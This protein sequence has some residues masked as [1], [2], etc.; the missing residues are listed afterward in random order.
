M[1]DET[2]PRPLGA[3]LVCPLLLLGCAQQNIAGQESRVRVMPLTLC[4]LGRYA[5]YS[6]IFDVVSTKQ[7]EKSGLGQ[8]AL[9]ARLRIVE[10]FIASPENAQ[11]LSSRS[12]SRE[13]IN[14]MRTAPVGTEVVARLALPDGTGPGSR[15]VAFIGHSH[16]FGYWADLNFQGA[17]LKEKDKYSNLGLYSQSSAVSLDE[18]RAEAVRGSKLPRDE[19]PSC[20]PNPIHLRDGGSSGV[21]GGVR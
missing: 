6:A 3:V 15:I 14:T 13:A 2:G 12:A 4:D 17:F 21:D 10:P 18:L 11:D 9:E 16:V 7:V 8:S 20:D 19:G 5:D 1:S